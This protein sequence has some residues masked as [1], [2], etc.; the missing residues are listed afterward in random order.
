MSFQ[1]YLLLKVGLSV[2]LLVIQNNKKS[3]ANAHPLITTKKLA[4]A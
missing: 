1:M 3:L 2:L 4:L